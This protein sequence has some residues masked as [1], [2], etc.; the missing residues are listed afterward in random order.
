MK[1][2]PHNHVTRVN[3]G[4]LPAVWRCR[5]CGETGTAEAL[6]AVACAYEYPPC[7]HCGQTPECARSC[8]GITALYLRVPKIIHRFIERIEHIPIRF[9]F[10]H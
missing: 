10:I 7:K 3:S 8:P 9:P 4:E 1:L 6:E 5:Y 2:N